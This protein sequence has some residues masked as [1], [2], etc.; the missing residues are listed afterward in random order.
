MVVMAHH[1]GS[2]IRLALLFLLCWAAIPGGAGRVLAAAPTSDRAHRI[3]AEIDDLWRADSSYGILRMKV[4]TAHYTRTVRMECWSLGRD[5]SLVRIISPLKEKG[6]VTLKSGN[7]IYTYLPRTD[8]TIRLTASM[9]LGSWMGSHFT[10][11]DLVK[12]SRLS[13]DYD[14]ELLFEGERDGRRILEFALHPKPEAAVVWGKIVITVLADGYLPLISRY[15]DDDGKLARTLYFSRIEEMGGR[16]L[17]TVMRMVPADKPGEYTELVYEKLAF[18][19]HLKD[20][21]F[22][23][24]ELRRE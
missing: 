21:F 20:S 9:M 19:V 22:S 11:D 12:D 7:A 24:Q 10:N 5:K 16:R 13:D 23:L 15:Y 4:V 14:P 6:T 17:P 1:P 18:G 8:R 2:I 3:L